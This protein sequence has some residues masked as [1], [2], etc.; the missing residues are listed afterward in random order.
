MTKKN[1]KT[2]N[3]IGSIKAG[4]VDEYIATYSKEVQ[5]KLQKI[6]AAIQ[7]VASGSIETISYFQMPG[8]SYAGYDYNGMFAWFSFKQPYVRLHVRPPVIQD[9]QKELIGFS[10]TRSIVSFSGDQ[11][12]PVALVKKLVKASLKEMKRKGKS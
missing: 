12:I 10:T 2:K 6:R 5:A 4:G 11:E 3:K 8:Y 9:H 1:P 7:A